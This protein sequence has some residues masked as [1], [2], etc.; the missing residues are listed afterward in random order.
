[1]IM[2]LSVEGSYEADGV[3]SIVVRTTTFL[4][5]SAFAEDWNA[6]PFAVPATA[7]PGLVR[8]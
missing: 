2:V 7:R 4:V 1:M 8:L 6:G 5:Q 3:T